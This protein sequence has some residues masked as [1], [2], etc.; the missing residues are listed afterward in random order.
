M[1]LERRD[2]S[3]MAVLTTELAQRFDINEKTDLSVAELRKKVAAV[4]F[5]LHDPDLIFY[6]PASPG[7]DTQDLSNDLPRKLSDADRE[8]FDAFQ[9]E[10][11]EQ[12]R[13]DAYVELDHWA[14]FGC[15]DGGR[16]VCVASMYPWDG[17]SIADLGVL[18]LSDVRGRG[19]ARATVTAISQFAR[20]KNYEPQ[21]RCQVDNG[22]SIALAKAC[23]FEPFGKWEVVQPDG[24]ESHTH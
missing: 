16:L 12:D 10:A 2:G 17:S 13:E 15:F 18:T 11:S 7:A 23:G 9:G 19:Y 24:P 1:I 22:A 14:V 20:D 6:L 5:T 21:Y 4:G 8:A 3:T